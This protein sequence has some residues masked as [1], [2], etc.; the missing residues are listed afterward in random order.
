MLT[1]LNI[2]F[3]TF[4]GYIL[5]TI[6][7][8]IMGK[9]EIGELSLFDFLILMSIADIMI[10]GIENF[11]NSIWYSIIPLIVIVC[12]Q[13]LVAYLSLKF[14]YIRSKIEGNETLIIY[15]G[16]ILLEDMKKEK[17]NMN[18]LYTQLRSKDIRSIDEVEYGILESNGNLSVFTFE[19]NKDET[20]PLPLI[21]SGKIIK[22][23]LKYAKVSKKWINNELKK[24]NIK[25]VKEVYGATLSNQKLNIVKY[26]KKS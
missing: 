11:E 26:I 5:L 9:R 25:S 10:I 6:S 2:L 8:R 23:N 13:K 15:K 17:Y 14:P 3:R 20:F 21:V 7:M 4:L 16:E 24:Q 19:E 18:D 22:Q 12:L 1:I